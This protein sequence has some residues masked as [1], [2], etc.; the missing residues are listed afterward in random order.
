MVLKKMSISEAFV[1]SY[2][3]R[4]RFVTIVIIIEQSKGFTYPRHKIRFA[5][6]Y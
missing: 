5:L 2:R 4:P 3:W 6:K 1:A